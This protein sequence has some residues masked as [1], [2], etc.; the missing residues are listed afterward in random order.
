[1]P[2]APVPLPLKLEWDARRYHALPHAGGLRDQP[3][4][5]LRDMRVCGNVYDALRIVD[6]ASKSTGTAWVRLQHEQ[7]QVWR[8]FGHVLE[9]RKQQRESHG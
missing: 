4:R 6:R 2:D 8:I 5:L 1:V 7:P 9:L 3:M